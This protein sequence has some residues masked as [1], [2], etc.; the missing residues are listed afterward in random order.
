M[1]Q[2]TREE[3]HAYSRGKNFS[4]EVSDVGRDFSSCQELCHFITE[5]VAVMFKEVIRLSSVPWERN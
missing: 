5:G 2:D 1:K 3:Q 4:W